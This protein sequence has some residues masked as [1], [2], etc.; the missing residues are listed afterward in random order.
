MKNKNRVQS[1]LVGPA[2]I[3]AALLAFIIAGMAQP[4]TPALVSTN[5]AFVDVTDQAGVRFRHQ[6]VVLDKK[7]ERIMP[8]MASIGACVAA[9][10]Y[11][12]DGWID[13]YVT[14]SK[15]G[16]LNKLYRNNGDGT[17]TDV[18][19][20]AG[21]ADVNRYGASIDAVWGDYDND[22]WPDLYIV[23]W[24]TNSLYHNNGD[25]TF[26]DVTAKAGV[27]HVGNGSCA[28]WFDY[29][30]DGLLDLYVCDYFQPVDLF[31]LKDTRIMHEDFE[32]AR[33]GGPK[34]LYRN[35]GDGTFT[36]VTK[37]AGVGDTGWTLDVAHGDYNND[38]Y[39]DLFLANDF[40]PD[41]VFRNNGDGTFTDVSDTTIGWDTYKGMNAE[42][43]DFNNDGWLDFYVCN[44]YSKEYV[45][46]G[47]RLH[48]NMGDG[49]FKD[50]SFEAG[51]FD[52]GWA[53]CGRF[54][55]YDN[56]GFLD[57][58]VANGYISANPKDEYFTKLATA[59][60]QPNFDPIDAMN[61]PVMGD[62]TF[63]GY[64]PKRVFHN[65][66][67][68]TFREV[69]AELG[70]NDTRDGRGLAMFDYDNNGTLDVY[71]SCQ[72]QD[73]VL[74]RN[75]I[76]KKNNW[77]EVDLQGTHCNRDAIGARITVWCG[78]KM[79]IREVNGGNGDHSQVPLRQHF[80]LAQA[81]AIDRLQIRWPNGY[82]E[83]HENLKPNQILKFVENAPASFLEERKRF[84]EAQIEG[85][86]QELAREKEKAEA[87]R[88]AQ[89]EESIDWNK[90]G[91]FKKDYLKCKTAVE[92]EPRNPQARYE[93]GVLLDRQDRQTAALGEF[94]KAMLLAPDQLLFANS[95]RALIRRYGAAYYDRA[96]RFFEDLTDRNPGKLMPALN[97][98]LAYVDKMPYPK[99]GIVA[100][101]KLSNKSIETLD[102]VLKNDP[103]CWAAK[104]VVA[105]NHLHWP[106]K[107]N[108]APIA[109][110]EFTELIALQKKLPPD[111]Q[112]DFFALGYVGLGDSYVK[113]ID[114]GQEENLALATKAWQDG[115]A[116]YPKS[117]D[118]KKRLELAK[119][120]DA[121]I[122]FVTDLRSLKN[123]VDTDL[124]QIWVER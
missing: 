121:I 103:D 78:D 86:K 66:G 49:T 43:G 19:Q 111:K 64:E 48:R 106:R 117:E 115:L 17:F 5:K 6:K 40:G 72:G 1:F 34:T 87:A 118:L 31:N 46:E 98:A 21:L 35:N 120:P 54:W 9:C 2:S 27:G 25:G 62:S 10:D 109:V 50:I 61:W 104:F 68:E 96:I 112:R 123:P 100:Q 110:K 105:M 88:N 74:W 65:E 22:G 95:Y 93:F 97:K 55:D 41:K 82:I 92:K 119:S 4:T 53:W 30:D 24:G 94:E 107:L 20:Q 81:K 67:N 101:G 15:L 26:T 113:N 33:N 89:K 79:Q 45:K 63:A 32:T 11:N 122:Q 76:G 73:G 85:R 58:M 91:A 69:A 14:S 57:I 44:I 29:N 59:V 39:Q 37:E 23:R 99:L 13:L 83:K 108:H 84:K 71:M 124:N 70:L 51:V 36:D 114:L 42:L 75:D 7:L 102:G 56:D 60:T 47:N 12:K 38:G 77:L 16:S 90:L 18:A 80:G 52:C 8:W 116:Q 3:A 28:I